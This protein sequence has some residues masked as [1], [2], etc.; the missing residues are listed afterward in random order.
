MRKN[1]TI[2][3]STWRE[4]GI[5]YLPETVENW[6]IGLTGSENYLTIAE[7]LVGLDDHPLHC[8]KGLHESCICYVHIHDIEIARDAKSGLEV[9]VEL[10]RH[11]DNDGFLVY[12]L[13]FQILSYISENFQN[14][15]F[16]LSFKNVNF[17][18]FSLSKSQSPNDKSNIFDYRKKGLPHFFFMFF[19][20]EIENIN[21]EKTC[22][23]LLSRKLIDTKS[24]YA[25][26]NFSKTF[27]TKEF[28]SVKV[29]VLQFL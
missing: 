25:K 28:F 7:D 9:Y 13:F 10:L 27:F 23:I 20:K 11:S 6:K 24:E 21:F 8:N 15:T 1:K 18:Q 5:Y 26:S 19:S 17:D 22:N 16:Q 3:Q 2:I 14:V 29:V 12:S 4:P